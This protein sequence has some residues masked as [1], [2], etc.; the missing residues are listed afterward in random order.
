MT[1]KTQKQTPYI[2]LD[3]LRAFAAFLVFF[4]HMR[5]QSF[6]TYSA[7]PKEDQTPLVTAFYAVT[8][9]GHEAVIIFFVLS[10]FFVGGRLIELV[11]KEQF[12]LRRY[13]IDRIS[14]IF[15]PFIPAVILTFCIA[16]WMDGVFSISQF[17]GTMLGLNGSFVDTP[18]RNGA[19]WSLAY[20]IWFYV[21]GGAAALLYSV[22]GRKIMSFILL[23]AALFVLCVLEAKYTLFW[24]LGALVPALMQGGGSAQRGLSPQLSILLGVFALVVLAGG[25]ALYQLTVDSQAV[26]TTSIIPPSG[27]EF[28]VALGT[29]LL[30]PVMTQ[31]W[32]NGLL[33]WL[34]KPAVALSA[35]S[36]TLYLFHLPIG[37]IVTEYLLPASEH[38]S[39]STLSVYGLKCALVL[40]CVVPIYFMFEHHTPRLRRWMSGAKT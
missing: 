1:V 31:P 36:Y 4:G 2:A 9:L 16:Y 24:I 35:I 32:M 38:V 5:L 14:R 30:L 3:L 13:T 27:A 39:L 28:L 17:V 23:G 37:F 40:G 22:S 7:L 8:R 29:C 18:D 20:E 12:S 21:F 26:T 10:G 19:L 15:L 25:V 11:Q 34:A 33:R 6:V